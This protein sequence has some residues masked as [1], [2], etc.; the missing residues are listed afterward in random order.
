MLIAKKKLYE[1]DGSPCLVDRNVDSDLDTREAELGLDGLATE[2]RS[3]EDDP[4]FEFTKS[5]E[6]SDIRALLGSSGNQD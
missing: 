4:F 1:N 3:Y 6:R 2:E 5:S